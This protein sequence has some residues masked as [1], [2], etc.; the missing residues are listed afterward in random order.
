MQRASLASLAL[1]VLISAGCEQLIG[2]E[3][4]PTP[5]P[6][7]QVYSVRRCLAIADAATASSEATRDD[8]D[9]IVIVPSPRPKD[10]H[11]VQTLGGAAPITVRL[12]MRDGTTFDTQMCAGIPSGPACSDEAPTWESGGD[13]IG[14]GYHDVPCAGEPPDGCPT[15]VPSIDPDVAL[16][17]TSIVVPSRSIPID[18][19]GAYEVSLGTGSLANGILTQATYRLADPWPV[20][21]TFGEGWPRLELRSLESDGQPFQ[22]VYEHGWRDGLERIEAVMVFD[23]KRFDPGATVDV[24]EV[25]VR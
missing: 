8:V 23:V 10:D 17:A 11:I 5:Q 18:H 19:V 3:P 7:G 21:V 12:V 6:C 9:T 15:A 13:L 2:R 14:S 24:L 25:V 1:V 4:D 16:A 20:D 22:N